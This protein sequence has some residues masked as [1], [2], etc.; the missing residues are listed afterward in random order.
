[1][2]KRLTYD[3]VV[4]TINNKTITSPSPEGSTRLVTLSSFSTADVGLS[5]ASNESILM[6]TAK[7]PNSSIAVSKNEETS[8][9]EHLPEAEVAFVSH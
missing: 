1:M 3:A 9:D 6:P 2:E 4:S 8:A 5:F 7:Q